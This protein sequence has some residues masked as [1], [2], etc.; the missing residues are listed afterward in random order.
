MTKI[1]PIMAQG[2]LSNPKIAETEYNE[3]DMAW[4]PKNFPTCL[5]EEC[6]LGDEYYHKCGFSNYQ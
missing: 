2:W 6:T 4:N 3:K 5:R 1:C